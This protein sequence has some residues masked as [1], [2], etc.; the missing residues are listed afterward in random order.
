MKKTIRKFFV[1]HLNECLVKRDTKKFQ[2]YL[3]QMLNETGKLQNMA[4]KLE[5]MPETLKDMLL[6]GGLLSYLEILEVMQSM[7][8]EFKRKDIY[9]EKK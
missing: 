7:K 9:S 8:L 3:Y 5:M 1:K 6:T 2:F 4:R